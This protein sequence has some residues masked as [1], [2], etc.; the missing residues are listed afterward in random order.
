MNGLYVLFTINIIDKPNKSTNTIR[1]IIQIKESDSASVTEEIILEILLGR[2][3]A[4][5]IAT[6]TAIIIRNIILLSM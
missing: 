4:H 3:C 6:I 1:L 5:G 2:T